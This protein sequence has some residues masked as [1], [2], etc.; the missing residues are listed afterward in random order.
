MCQFYHVETGYGFKQSIFDI[1]HN[2]K[3]ETESA[4]QSEEAVYCADQNE[5]AIAYSSFL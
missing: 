4:G 1:K 5:Q 2:H 3:Y